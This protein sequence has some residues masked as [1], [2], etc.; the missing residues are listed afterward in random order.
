MTALARGTLSDS[1]GIFRME[2]PYS[3]V[4]LADGSFGIKPEPHPQDG[5]RIG[6]W[7]AAIADEMGAQK[8]AQSF[9][10]DAKWLRDIAAAETNNAKIMRWFG[11]APEDE[12]S[13]S[14]VLKRGVIS[15]IFGALG[16][17]LLRAPRSEKSEKSSKSGKS[18]KVGT[19]P[20]KSKT[21]SSKPGKSK[22]SEKS[23]E[24]GK[25]DQNGQ[26][27]N[28]GQNTPNGQAG[29][30][31]SKAPVQPKLPTIEVLW[32]D[33]DAAVRIVAHDYLHTPADCLNKMSLMQL[34]CLTP[35]R[36]REKVDVVRD[37][38]LQ[39]KSELPKGFFCF[40]DVGSGATLAL[41][42]AVKN[43]MTAKAAH[44]LIV[45]PAEKMMEAL[46]V[47]W[48]EDVARLKL[49]ELSAEDVQPVKAAL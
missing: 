38:L 26:S 33:Y 34:V 27:G 15:S 5:P 40:H 10:D 17:L 6:S 7:Q 18:G 11:Q 2:A 23:P 29:T 22:P 9:L 47:K 30:A 43:G 16:G 41:H 36:Q 3:L 13:D 25:S 28:S 35:V 32:E 12:E 37:L 21:G 31:T 39:G 48:N 20:S 42:Q 49:F 44:E 4:K 46:L 8:D 45:G 1:R 14:V 19:Q 24:S